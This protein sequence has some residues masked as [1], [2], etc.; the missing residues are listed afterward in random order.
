MTRLSGVGNLLSILVG[1]LLCAHANAQTQAQPRFKA[2]AFDYF[3][4][5]DANSVIPEAERAFPGRGADFTR[6]WR[7]KQ[8][9]YSFLRSITQRLGNR[10]RGEESRGLNVVAL[11]AF[12]RLVPQ[13]GR[14]KNPVLQ[15]FEWSQRGRK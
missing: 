8:F 6:M 2:V 14:N 4:I 11:A 15:V 1:L 13:V 7:T 3:V 12:R 5:F 10:G 9:E